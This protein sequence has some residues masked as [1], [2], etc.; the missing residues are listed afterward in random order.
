MKWRVGKSDPGTQKCNQAEITRL[1]RQVFT[2]NP[3]IMSLVALTA[4]C[5]CV[6]DDEAHLSER[7]INKLPLWY[8]VEREK[9]AD[10][11][12]YIP[13][14]ISLLYN[15]YIYNMY[16]ERIGKSLDQFPI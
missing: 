1:S 8:K 16:M 12:F 7:S 13:C 3:P 10:F 15:I 6:L 14:F 2:Q 9:G 11:Y 5:S 4:K